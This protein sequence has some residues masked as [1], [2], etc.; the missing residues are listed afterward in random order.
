MDIFSQ[1]HEDK[2]DNPVASLN[3]GFDGI[4]SPVLQ[5]DTNFKRESSFTDDSSSK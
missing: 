1:E 3:D 2:I 4:Q 5:N